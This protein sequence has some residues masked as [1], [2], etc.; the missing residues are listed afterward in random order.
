[1][2]PDK[3]GAPLQW[4]YSTGDRER[5]NDI[6]YLDLC[7]A[8]DNTQISN[9]ITYLAINCIKYTSKKIT[10]VE[11]VSPTTAYGLNTL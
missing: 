3:S 4:G 8:F 2:V 11:T 9:K 5:A 10:Q 1:M 6:S 7:K